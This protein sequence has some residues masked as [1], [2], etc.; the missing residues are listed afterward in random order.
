MLIRRLDFELVQ[1]MDFAILAL[2]RKPLTLL[3]SS[4]F[5]TQRRCYSSLNA[6]HAHGLT[7]HVGKPQRPD[8]H[9]Y[10]RTRRSG[11]AARDRDGDEHADS[12]AE[13]PT[14]RRAGDDGTRRRHDGMYPVRQ[15]NR[16]LAI[17]S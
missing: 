7:G 12:R 6:S 5:V 11:H 17:L 3:T 16:A 4:S 13:P 8:V 10:Q 9:P 15:N 1:Q 2:V 14:C